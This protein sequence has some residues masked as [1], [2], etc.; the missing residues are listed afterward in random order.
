MR[1]V[2]MDFKL[3]AKIIIQSVMRIILLFVALTSAGLCNAQVYFPPTAGSDW[4]TTNPEELGWCQ[5]SIDTLLSY[6]EA[7]NT[8][9]FMVLKDGRIVL[10][11]YFD[12]F[13]QNDIWY[14]ASAGKTIT[15]T[16]VGKSL[17]EGLLNLED[18]VS[19]YLGQGWTSCPPEEEITRT[20][21]HQLSM[22]SSFNNSILWWDCTDP[23]C[24]QCTELEVGSQWH[25]HNGVYRRLIEVIEAATGGD[26]NQLTNEWIEE[27][28]GMSG[29]WLENLYFSRHR[30]MARFG[31]LALNNFVWDGNPVLTNQEFIADLASPSQELNPSY[32]Y[33]WW[34]NGQE[35]HMLPLVPTPF[36]GWIVPSGPEDMF[37]A[38]G[39]NDQ[40]IY[41]VPSQN[42]I[43]TRQ[44]DAAYDEPLAASAF[45][46]ELW[47]LISGLECN[48]LSLSNKKEQRIRLIA[49]NPSINGISLIPN[50]DVSGPVKIYSI[51]GKQIANLNQEQFL[52]LENG[53]YILQANLGSGEKIIQKVLVQ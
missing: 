46:V 28:T 3:L 14:W 8:K 6:L 42:L 24:F 32:G 10:E 5:E 22:S 48:P 11:N 43:V 13:G 25:Y 50:Q 31:L 51:T 41:L 34:L 33:L 18:P 38:L 40:K 21:F 53:I 2:L 30:D 19:D 29:F 15:A 17:E 47:E 20:I 27:P 45:D 49:S 44:G 23:G 9:A 4:E 7:R 16:L 35:S 37:M 52:P 12:G 26:R 1:T 36:E 39:A